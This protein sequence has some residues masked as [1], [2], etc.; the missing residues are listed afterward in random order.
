MFKS[1]QLKKVHLEISNRCQASCPMC[2]R[3]IHGGPE[4]SLLK[5][6]DWTYDNFVKIFTP[7][8]LSNL[9][10]MTFCGTFGDPMLNNQLIEMCEYVTRTAP[11]VDIRV[12]T[13]GSA[14]SPAWWERL[15]LALPTKHQVIFALDGLEDTQALYRIGT[16]FNKIIKNAQAFINAG[17]YATWMFIRFK[18]NEHQVGQAEQVAKEVGF[19][20]FTLKNTRRFDDNEFTVIDREGKITHKLEQ[21][22]DNV[23]Q[24][25][26]RKAIENY[27]SWPNATDINCFALDTKEIYIDAHYTILPCCIISSF[28]YT[29]YND[30]TFVKYGLYNESTSMN[31][32]G[33][34]I[35]S[36]VFDIIE[37]LGGF[38]SI[39]ASVNGIEK[40]VDSD[41]WQNIWHDK[42]E[43]KASTTCIVMCSKDTP[44]ITL[45]EQ[46]T[47]QK[48]L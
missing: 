15:A 36:E 27:A 4:N 48:K 43:Q 42:W 29:N 35:Q 34:L 23:I 13:N 46:R 2:P 1:S 8:I 39:D 45:Q 20:E 21:P 9:E 17:G 18:H 37:E 5:E 25:V 14:R 6:N 32:M 33:R 24:F 28:L 12:H 22:S 38:E 40:I 26:N 10:L 41:L 19:K 31:T 7:A 30:S 3:N 16:D 47:V 11:H 44:Y